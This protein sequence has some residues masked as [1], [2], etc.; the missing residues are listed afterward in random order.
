[1]H[2]GPGLANRV[3]YVYRQIFNSD[4]FLKVALGAGLIPAA[5]V[6]A[7]AAS[8]RCY[9]GRTAQ[10]MSNRDFDIA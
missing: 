10:A 5:L 7:L 4:D 3:L 2:M 1:M 6:V 9:S 8:L